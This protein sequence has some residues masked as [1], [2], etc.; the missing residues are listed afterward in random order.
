M[1]LRPLSIGS[2]AVVFLL[3]G[4]VVAGYGPLLEHLTRRFNVSLPVAGATISVQYIGAL[5]GVLV[6]MRA[7]ERLRARVIVAVSCVVA[8]F[9]LAV[10]AVAPGW[11]QFLGGVFIFGLGFGGLDL[12]VNQVVAYSE[13][14]RRAALLN[15]LNSAYP[16][17]AVAG[18][19][20]V[21]AFAAEH[22]TA[23]FLVASAIW[24]LL[25]PGI[26]AITGRV[27][28]ETEAARWP[29]RLVMLFVA[30]FMLYVA[31]EVGT[32]GWMT[33]HLES[34]GFG[35]DG[36]AKLTSA[37]W[38]ALVT[39]RL[40]IAMVP[41]TVREGTIVLIAS[42]AA[43]VALG[44]ATIGHLAPF[45]YV[46]AGLAMAPIF[47]TGIVWLAK[48]RPGDSRATAW[49]YPAAS[50]GGALGPGAI[51]IVIAEA[52]VAWAPA[53]LAVVAAAMYAAFMAAS[54]R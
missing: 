9:G 54:R 36:A 21:S 41:S 1:I 51:G 24:L 15:A 23:L 11:S 35:S 43:T 4:L 22:F 19:I 29:G 49:L 14:G 27:P 39:G 53:V 30:A 7:I 17:G 44:F 31:L 28:V 18:P 25:L 2:M 40:L 52:G 46:A 32:G 38:F 42:A 37:F 6:S 8:S 47:P 13:G 20:L 12:S 26:L 33:S 34:V 5:V 48:L 10:V 16:A 3:M 50:V 45:A